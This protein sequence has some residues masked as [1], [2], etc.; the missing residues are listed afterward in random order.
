MRGKKLSL[1]TSAKPQPLPLDGS[2]ASRSLGFFLD[3]L[4]S[5][6]LLSL[7]S[8]LRGGETASVWRGAAAAAAGEVGGGQGKGQRMESRRVF[9]CFCM[10][11]VPPSPGAAT[12]VCQHARNAY[13]NERSKDGRA[14]REKITSQCVKLV[15]GSPKT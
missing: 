7:P 13:V 8:G 10:R 15:H 4:L 6:L 1:R 3:L 11:D 2:S 12:A 14:P 5:T 9:C